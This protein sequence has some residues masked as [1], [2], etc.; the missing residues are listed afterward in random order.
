MRVVPLFKFLA[1]RSGGCEPA[2]RSGRFPKKSV[3]VVLPATMTFPAGTPDTW[4]GI[5]VFRGKVTHWH[6]ADGWGHMVPAGWDPDGIAI[7]PGKRLGSARQK[8]RRFLAA[9]P[10]V[11]R[12]VQDHAL[13][14]LV[15]EG[16]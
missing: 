5:R 12:R 14:M 15:R 4:E 16:D 3:V 9:F 11:D 7:A 13:R 1:E 2:I 6:N 8:M 10:P